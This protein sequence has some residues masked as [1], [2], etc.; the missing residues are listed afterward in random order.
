M[1][2][3]QLNNSIHTAWMEVQYI[4]SAEIDGDINS[5]THVSIKY[6]TPVLT[7]FLFCHLFTQQ[8]AAYL[9]MLR[10]RSR[11]SGHTNSSPTS[12]PQ[13]SNRRLSMAG[14]AN[15]FAKMRRFEDKTIS[16]DELEFS[17][18]DPK[19]HPDVAESAKD[20]NK[21][22][23]QQ[24]DHFV[25]AGG[26]N[27][28]TL[29]RIT[30]IALMENAEREL[31]ANSVVDEQCVH[32]TC[33]YSF[34][35]N[36]FCYNRWEC[37]VSGPKPVQSGKYKVLVWAMHSLTLSFELTN[38]KD[39]LHC[40]RNY[41]IYIRLPSSRRTRSGQK[42][43]WPHVHPP[44]KLLMII[45]DP[46]FWL[47]RSHSFLWISTIKCASPE[48]LLHYFAYLRTLVTFS[49]KL[50]NFL[51]SCCYIFSFI[52]PHSSLCTNIHW[53]SFPISIKLSLS[54]YVFQ[55]LFSFP[56]LSLVPYLSLQPPP[57][58]W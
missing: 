13:K 24:T 32:S 4:A 33:F 57:K 48:P 39:S 28:S 16:T 56:I 8:S 50:T 40:I 41:I 3:C 30:R 38:S 34:Y 55:I 45:L 12:S 11:S 36:P 37:T 6:L 2:R 35:S 31:G 52:H 21:V 17:S 22:P 18:G 43:T 15:L 51:L 27:L 42:Y 26:V 14:V 1:V 20:N 19:T 7:F 9:P 29:L 54:F 47:N 5:A 49:P 58:N 10:S 44:T 53:T 46:H 23:V 25:C